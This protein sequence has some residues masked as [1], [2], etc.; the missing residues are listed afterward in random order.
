L[1]KNA[2]AAHYTA[3]AR[4]LHSGSGK[5]L[6][7]REVYGYE[8]SVLSNTFHDHVI[9]SQI[10]PTLA[11]RLCVASESLQNNQKLFFTSW[12]KQEIYLKQN[13][14][15]SFKS[16][17]N[18]MKRKIR[19][20]GNFSSHFTTPYNHLIPA[21]ML[22]GLIMP[23]GNGYTK[24]YFQQINKEIKRFLEQIKVSECAL[25][26]WLLIQDALIFHSTGGNLWPFVSYLKNLQR[27]ITSIKLLAG[28]PDLKFRP[29]RRS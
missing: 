10:S 18:D 22:P 1:Q 7:R 3:P 23:R 2:T 29:R 5:T 13:K 26:I 28:I 21:I 20:S 14:L 27:F 15:H 25:K 4:F 6:R 24:I 9:V 16:G 8:A 12:S 17:V 19:D 11:S